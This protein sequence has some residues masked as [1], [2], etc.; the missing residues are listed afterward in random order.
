MHTAAFS[1]ALEKSYELPDGN[2]D[3]CP[4]LLFQSRFTFF[5]LFVHILLPS[6]SCCGLVDI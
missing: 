4:E 1:S 2:G 5:D 3:R 6:L